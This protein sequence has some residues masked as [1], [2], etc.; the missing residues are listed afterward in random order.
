V[1][2]EA[3]VL[4][5]AQGPFALETL[6]LAGPGPGQVLVRI[7][8]VGMCHTDLAIRDAP[9]IAP[10]P[11]IEGHEGAG[12]VE[13]VGAAVTGVNVGDHVVLSF[14]TCGRCSQ[15]RQGHPMF[16]PSFPALNFGG[17]ELDGSSP[18]TDREG[19]PVAA[20]WFGQSSFAT[21]A[22]GS[23][24]NTVPVDPSVPL[25]ILG[26]LGCGVLTG[27]CAVLVAT[28]VPAG[29]S[30]A[31]FGAGAV[32]LSAIMAARL[33]GAT[34]IVAIDLHQK[35]LDLAA[36]LGATHA[37]TADP[38]GVSRAIIDSVGT[39]DYVFDTTGIPAVQL[40]AVALL[41]RGG[42][43]GFIAGARGPSVLDTRSL[44]GGKTV[45][46]ISGGDAVPHVHIPRLVELWKQGR[47]PFDRLTQTFRLEEIN[48]AER[49]T[50][51]GDVVKP[52]LLPG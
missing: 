35:R 19:K 5:S 17:L 27:A 34:T 9:R 25:E 15:C 4:R 46:G 42:V 48:D 2:I 36:E 38:A 22:L 29:A 10:L 16:C 8:S 39:I 45:I 31:V 20:R 50:L 6:D 44:M 18:V 13:A 11:L 30:A 1:K 14:D 52:V 47:F 7:V 33:A 23:E 41:G 40:D 3:A 32:G 28:R 37:F 49:A 12:V 43:C 26:P 24:R 51:S 21:Y